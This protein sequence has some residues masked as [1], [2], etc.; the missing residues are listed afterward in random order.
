MH[1]IYFLERILRSRWLKCSC[2]FSLTLL[3]FLGCSPTDNKNTLFVLIDSNSSGLNFENSISSTDSLNILNYIY[4]FNGG[5]VGIGDINNDGLEDVFFAGNLVSSKLY[6]NLGGLKFKDITIEAGVSTEVWCTGISMIDIN[7]DGYLDIYV[8]VAG[9]PQ[10]TKRA[11]LLFINNGDL[12][13]T[14]SAGTYGIDH[15]GYTT[16]SAF[17]DYDLDGDL[18]LYVM[19]HTE[20]RTALNTPVKRKLNG[21]SPTTDVLFRNDGNN[22]FTDISADAGISI[23]GYGLGLAINDFNDD[24]F[25]DIYVSND[26][27][28][29]DLMYINNRDGTFSNTI[30]Q[31]IEQQSYNGMGVDVA[32]I[33][34]DNMQD[35]IVLDMLPPDPVRAKT[36]AGSMTYDKFL[37]IQQMN[38]EPQFVR[39]T[40]QLNQ[41]GV[42]REI[43]RYSGIHRTDWSW[44]PLFMDADGDGWKDLFISNGY[45]KDIT[46]KDFM[47][48]ENNLSFFKNSKNSEKEA[49]K[50]IDEQ[51]SVM[52]ANYI[53]SNN[54]DLTFT[55]K[56][57]DWG[58]DYKSLSNGA[59]YADLD[60]D[61]DLD[62]L[63]NNI[64][65][66]AFLF[67]NKSSK[68][69]YLQLRFEGSENNPSALGSKIQVFGNDQQINFYQNP[70]RGFMS[71]VSTVQTIGL[72]DMSSVD[73]LVITW[74]D[75]KRSVQYTIAADQRVEISYDNAVENFTSPNFNQENE[76]FKAVS[77]TGLELEMGIDAINDF[78]IQPLLPHK[79]STFSP[80]MASGD[81]NGDGVEDLFVGGGRNQPSF[82]FY[83]K[84]GRFEKSEL[85]ELRLQKI[86]DVTV[87]DFSG[88]GIMDIYL[89]CGNPELNTGAK[90]QKDHL[91][92]GGN[93]IKR[94]D[95][96]PEVLHNSN[97]VSS[98]DINNDGHLDIFVGS[99]PFLLDYP[100][101]EGGYV[102]INNG[103]GVFEF[104]NIPGLTYSGIINDSAPIDIDNDGDNDLIIAS[105]WNPIYIL[106][107]ENGVFRSSYALSKEAGFWKSILSMDVDHDGDL[108]II[109]GN[110]GLNGPLKASLKEPITLYLSDAETKGQLDPLFTHFVNGQET[111]LTSRELLFSRYPFFSR[112]FKT[113]RSFAQSTVQDLL[114]EEAYLN[115]KR[116]MV[117]SLASKVYLNNGKMDFTSKNLPDLLQLFSHSS[118][119][120]LNDG[121]SIV[122]SNYQEHMFYDGQTFGSGPGV[123]V[124]L[125]VTGKNNSKVQINPKIIPNTLS[126]LPISIH[127]YG[128]CMVLIDKKGKLEV[129]KLNL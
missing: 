129:Y 27:I 66:P 126:I 113:H 15:Q 101:T 48:Y 51:P 107:N 19:N 37:T 99:G 25:P 4:F 111:L 3:F 21:E 7:T 112:K 58:L 114:G 83:Q 63:I 95:G 38:Y 76:M 2:T 118:M 119:V 85:P 62:I 13:F 18:D 35:I 69:H 43:G 67:E 98:L 65:Q 44:A 9:S 17:F 8:S 47:D 115:T 56:S 77:V 45:L 57:K 36:M 94:S 78:K 117:Q 79:L 11:N 123:W 16:H 92:L 23:E 28:T 116:M 32:D 70:Y 108:D 120:E 86:N 89:A 14:E 52:L 82:I 24:G 64:N 106:I 33:N 12:T 87:A 34:N 100:R 122:F 81:F 109:A 121:N 90:E 31:R 91:Y 59:A 128:T 6:L 110:I 124:D 42:F 97:T 104:Q 93:S 54:K 50:R 125:E 61:G 60:N 96:L 88:D 40:L 49:L 5:G 105:D 127:G 84:E 20:D 46:D 55:N 53:F 80:V 39:N 72:G 102:L 103:K 41:G 75:G 1:I 74:P 71:S 73:S 29:N 22:I 30:A 26:F 68:Y 10:N